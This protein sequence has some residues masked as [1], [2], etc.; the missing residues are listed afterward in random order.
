M[1]VLGI[2]IVFVPLKS[3]FESFQVPR[4]SQSM[5]DYF[6]SGLPL[7]VLGVELYFG[8]AGGGCCLL[9]LCIPPNFG[10]LRVS[11][12]CSATASTA[13]LLLRI[14][15]PTGNSFFF[16]ACNVFHYPVLAWHARGRAT[17]SEHVQTLLIRSSLP[18]FCMYKA[19]F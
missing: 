5:I 2:L 6:F 16:F 8:V 19:S 17:D 3:T 4:N 9:T 7:L 18:F 14:W 10:G 13:V 15:T 11:Q 12:N 1:T